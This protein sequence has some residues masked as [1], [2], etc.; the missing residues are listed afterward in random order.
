M[1]SAIIFLVGGLLAR[2]E[3]AGVSEP[4]DINLANFC[5]GSDQLDDTACI[6]QWIAAGRNAPHS[7]LR[8]ISGTYFYKQS[9]QLFSGMN[10][11]CSGTTNVTFKNIG[12]T[13]TFLAAASPVSNVR[14]AHCAFDV[15][16]NNTN[17]LAV[18]SVNP[19]GTVPSAAIQVTDNVFRDGVIL[20]QMSASQRQYILLLNCADCRAE[21]NHLSEG[22]R[23]K[24]GRPGQR[25]IIRNNIVEQANDNAITVVDIGSGVTD[26]VLIEANRVTSPKGVGIFFGADGE[27]QT[28]PA[29][30]TRH[31]RVAN[32][33]V[34]G[35]WLTACILGTLPEKAY[36]IRVQNN[37]CTKTGTAGSFQAGILVKR[38]NN[39]GTR[40]N[41]IEV[42]KNIVVSPGCVPSGSPA[43]L[44]Y[45]GIYISGQY[46][47]ATISGN[48][49]KN[50]GPRAMFLNGVDILNAIIVHNTLEGGIRVVNGTVH[51]TLS[52]NNVNPSCA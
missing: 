20:G 31:V 8:A 7:K 6:G 39:A 27:A 36:D 29:L 37:H 47:K 15:N 38:I 9:A 41:D 24:M 28:D 40:A 14:I 21:R 44:D 10:L 4:P 12:G 33:V 45:G 2:P 30:T 13:G 52:P 51:G 19:G 43:P 25:L 46:D 16:G 17:F 3:R 42:N 5:N 50:V 34:T 22:G 18:I 26:D 32:N 48:D 11:E 35:D 1:R 23:I 49:I